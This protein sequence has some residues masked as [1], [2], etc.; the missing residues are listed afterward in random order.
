VSI[1][2]TS[3]TAVKTRLPGSYV[4]SP[5]RRDARRHPYTVLSYQVAGEL[6]IEHGGT[7]TLRVGDLH[8]IPAGHAHSLREAHDVEF[9]SVAL[10]PGMLAGERHAALLA[11]LEPFAR[12]ALSRVTVPGD[13]RAFVTSLFLE[14]ASMRP[15]S[16]LRNES[17]LVLLL[18]ELAEHAPPRAAHHAPAGDLAS[19]VLAFIA[20]NALGPLSLDDVARAV[21]R[22]RTHVAD[23]VRRETGL[24][25]GALITDV[26]LDEARRRLEETDELIEVI[27]E[28]VGYA[29]AT[30]FA[31]MFKRR[32]GSAPRA[33]RQVQ[34]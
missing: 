28:R 23:V 34:R 26:R 14:L 7:V 24:S 15:A 16:T 33:W 9:W 29:D 2:S 22:S 13:R 25:V 20:A 1:A 8:V 31:R 17:L 18:A 4:R 27:G 10:G 32:F 6:A 11:P 19:R 30:H 21:Q 3:L 5:T 12:G